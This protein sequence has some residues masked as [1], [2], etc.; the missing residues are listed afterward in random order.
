MKLYCEFSRPRF[1]K[2]SLRIKGRHTDGSAQL[3]YPT[4]MRAST[5][6][7]F[8]ITYRPFFTYWNTI[9]LLVWVC[10]CVCVY[11]YYTSSKTC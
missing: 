11:G 1:H 5:P 10:N 2:P 3:N 8:I 7:R 4:R 9:V 6:T